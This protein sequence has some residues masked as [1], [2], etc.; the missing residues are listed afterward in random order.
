MQR[1]VVDNRYV[2]L[3]L[4]GGVGVVKVDL[5]CGR[6]LERR[7]ALEVE[8]EAGASLDYPDVVQA[9]D[10]GETEDGTYYAAMEYF[11]GGTLEDRILSVARGRGTVPTTSNPDASVHV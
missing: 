6:I 7:V 5:A 2:F 9:Y 10:R 8:R 4:L 1:S 3:H 11:P